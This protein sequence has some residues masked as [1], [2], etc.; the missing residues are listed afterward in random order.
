[1]PINAHPDYLAAEKEYHLNQT[2]EGKLKA[3]EK[4]ISLA[5]KH[6]KDRKD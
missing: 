2:P 5:P 6:I 4:M 3:L 1:M